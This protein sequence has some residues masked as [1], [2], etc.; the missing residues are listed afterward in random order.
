MLFLLNVTKF[1]FRKCLKVSESNALRYI[2]V[3]NTPTNILYIG[4]CI[5]F[6]FI[7]QASIRYANSLGGG[8]H[9]WTTDVRRRGELKSYFD[10]D[11]DYPDNF[12]INQEDYVK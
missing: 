6:M 4:R 10:V 2:V 1:Q 7:I 12:L 9:C 11:Y 3:Y 5:N 8:F